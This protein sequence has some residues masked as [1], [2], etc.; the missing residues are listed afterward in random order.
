M[1]IGTIAGQQQHDMMAAVNHDEFARQSFVSNFMRDVNTVLHEGLRPLCDKPGTPGSLEQVVRQRKRILAHPYG[2]MWSSLRRIGREMH[3]DVVGPAVERQL[4]GLIDKARRYRTSNRKLG[5]LELDPRVR[6]PRY[7]TEIEIHIKPGGYHTDLC[8]DDVFAGAEYERTT[9]MNSAGALGPIQDRLGRDTAQWV[10]RNY[11]KL[12]PKRILEMGCTI[13][14]ST[15]GWVDEFPEAEVYGIDVGAPVLRYAHARAEA[16]GRPVHFAQQ[17]AEKTKYPDNYFDIVCSHAMIH[18]TSV[19]TMH[20][21]L[22]ETLRILKPGGLMVHNDG[23]PFRDLDPLGRVVPDWD[24]HYNA[25][26]FITTLRA[27]DL[28]KWAIEAGWD[29]KKVRNDYSHEGPPKGKEIR[30]IGGAG[31]LLIGQK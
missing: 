6:A 23:T 14:S 17:D 1:R 10:K 24:T 9:Y 5:S 30:V 15:I 8:P 13:G 7:N 27:T 11:P 16:L 28:T 29:P 19:K 20:H 26:P 12:R 21:I 31:Y 2:Q 18:E 3:T 4:S 22:A 25:E